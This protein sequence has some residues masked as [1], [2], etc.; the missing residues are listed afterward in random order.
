MNSTKTE[1]GFGGHF[2]RLVQRYVWDPEPWNNETPKASIWCLGK[3]YKPVTAKSN[4][5]KVEDDRSSLNP[6]QDLDKETVIIPS[7]QLDVST[8]KSCDA[9]G[10]SML[11]AAAEEER[12]R[13][14]PAEFLDDF[15]SRFWFTYR[16]GFVPIQKSTDPK[17]ASAMSLGVR[18]RSQLLEQSG[19]TS[20]TGWGCMI[21]SGQ[22]LI[23]NALGILRLGRGRS[24]GEDK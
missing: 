14:W 15:E 20:D 10:G 4:D 12:Q 9:N 13:G 5:V 24:Y 23:A 11:S 1:T 17:A 3:E 6:S 2:Q 16:S 7:D 19:F 21:R 22:C 8:L 18:L